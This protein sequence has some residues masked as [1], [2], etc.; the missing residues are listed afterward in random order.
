MFVLNY[1]SILQKPYYNQSA[2]AIPQ[3]FSLKRTYVIFRTLGL[4]HLTVIDT[5]NII[6]GII[7]RKDLMGFNL[8]ERL[9]RSITANLSQSLQPNGRVELQDIAGSSDQV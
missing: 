5:K 8:Q 9:S 1:N 4:R 2:L 3:K 6:K 7:T